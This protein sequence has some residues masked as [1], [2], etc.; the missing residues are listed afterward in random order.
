[1]AR[2]LLAATVEAAG[3]LQAVALARIGGSAEAVLVSVKEA[4]ESGDREPKER[5]H[6]EQDLPHGTQV[7]PFADP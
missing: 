5:G 2:T 7:L 6:D 3:V 1:M 4:E